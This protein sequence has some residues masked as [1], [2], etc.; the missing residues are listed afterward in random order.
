MNDIV[1]VSNPAEFLRNESGTF[2]VTSPFGQVF[3]VT[4]RRGSKMNVRQI[5]EPQN[6][7][8]NKKMIWKILRVNNTAA[9]FAR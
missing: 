4:C 1:E 7:E 6:I 5:S 2:E 8:N 3:W 9:Q